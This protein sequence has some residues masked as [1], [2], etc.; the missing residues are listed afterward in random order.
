MNK[1][2][3]KIILWVIFIAL[4]IAGVVFLKNALEG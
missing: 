2:F 3:V 4:F 1:N